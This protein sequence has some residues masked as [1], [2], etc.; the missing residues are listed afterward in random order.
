V[1][2]KKD[3]WKQNLVE[4]YKINIYM[5]DYEIQN[6][7]EKELNRQQ[8]G[9]E[10]IPSENFPSIEV[11]NALSSVLNNKYSEGYPKKRYYGGNQFIDQIEELA[12]NRVKKLFGAEH[13][14]VQPLSGSPANL[15]VY[16]ALLEPNDKILGMSL[17]EGGHLTHGHKV[18]FSG[19][20]FNSFQYGI[21]KETHLIDYDKIA[22]IASI[23][24]PKLIIA[25]ATA[26]PREYNFKKFEK[27]ALENNCYFMADIS[28]IAGLIA[29][30]VHQNPI[31][32]AD[33]VTTTTHKTLRGPRGGVIMCKEK[34]TNVIDKSVFP[35][36][37]GGPHEH[38]IAAKA[39][40]FKEAMKESFKTYGKQIIVNAKKLAQILNDGGMNLISGG[41]DNHLILA[42][43]TQ[44]Q[45]SGKYAEEILDKCF[46]TVNRNTIPFD[47]KTPLNPSGIRL[48][49]PALTTRGMK[50][51]EMEEIGMLILSALKTRGDPLVLK[52]IRNE[53][54]KL[55]KEFPIYQKLNEVKKCDQ[56]LMN[57]LWK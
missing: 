31:P 9:L 13:A 28:H 23:V 6:I 16:L 19:K 25:G 51:T 32:F 37:Q 17:A 14:N 44:F 20:L 36:L 11:L 2:L 4:D 5:T 7:I 1:F 27:I 24:K 26:Y 39:I 33:V 18:N 42:D 41:T 45:M 52:N 54:T 22:E 55:C 12:I 43:V 8:N 34:Y 49:T 46:I 35:G 21:S 40:C 38:V 56:M 57:I 15:A 48:G 50:E 3:V 10:M 47:T 53:V 30:D 29:A